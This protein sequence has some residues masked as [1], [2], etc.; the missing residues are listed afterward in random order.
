MK[1][2]VLSEA[3]PGGNGTMTVIGFSGKGAARAGSAAAAA[4]MARDSVFQVFIG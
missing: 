2:A 4:S 1:R 3:P